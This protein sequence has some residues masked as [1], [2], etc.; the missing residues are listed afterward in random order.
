MPGHHSFDDASVVFDEDFVRS[1]TIHEPSAQARL[2]AFDNDAGVADTA[3]G[4][5]RESRTTATWPPARVVR[6]PTRAPRGF[7]GT[8]R[9][10]VFRHPLLCRL[11]AIA[12]AAGVTLG[13]LALTR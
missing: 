10:F 8:V 7:A 12:G 1:A 9:G 11:A 6:L 4:S 3:A 5:V 13:V 2:R